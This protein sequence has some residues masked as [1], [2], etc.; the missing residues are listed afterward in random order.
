[1][2]EECRSGLAM[3]SAK[4]ELAWVVSNFSE[5]ASKAFVLHKNWRMDF[6]YN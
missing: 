1:M 6:T 4:K 2:S 5:K 3:L